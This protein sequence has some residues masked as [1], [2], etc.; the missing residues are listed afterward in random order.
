M[1]SPLCDED[2]VKYAGCT[3]Y[4]RGKKIIFANWDGISIVLKARG[5]RPLGKLALENSDMQMYSKSCVPSVEKYISSIRDLI[6]SKYNTNYTKT[7]RE[8][9]SLLWKGYESDTEIISVEQTADDAAQRAIMRSLWSLIQ[10]DEFLFF[11]YFSRSKFIPFIFGSCG[12][13]YAV[14]SAPPTSVLHPGAMSIARLSRDSWH[15]R[16]QAAIGLLDIIESAQSEFHEYLHLCDI[17]G[18]NFGIAKDGNIKAIDMDMVYFDSKLGPW[19]AKNHTHCSQ[20]SDCD[21]ISCFGQ[22]N[23]TVGRCE[24]VINN[25]NLEVNIVPISSL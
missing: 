15:D 6:H 10:Q 5:D 24:E 2:K 1:C 7:D 17:K 14:D 3:N 8:L 18:K 23:S 12:H 25:N 13:V 20:N 21:F 19:L 22:C 11:R 4:L 9:I 16:A